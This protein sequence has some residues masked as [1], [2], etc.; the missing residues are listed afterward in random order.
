MDEIKKDRSAA[1]EHAC[2]A[3]SEFRKSVVSILPP[4]VAQHGR[5]AQKEVLLAFRSLIDAAINRID[6]RQSGSAS[7]T[8][9]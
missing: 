1:W 3:G 9:Q 7:P 6:R 4:E 2:T 5:A 8:G